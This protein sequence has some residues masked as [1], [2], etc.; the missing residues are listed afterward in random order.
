MWKA[1]LRW[2]FCE[3][4][5]KCEQNGQ[6]P[7]DFGEYNLRVDYDCLADTLIGGLIQEFNSLERYHE[8][9]MNREPPRGIQRPQFNAGC[10]SGDIANSP[11]GSIPWF[12]HWSRVRYNLELDQT[13]PDVHRPDQDGRLWHYRAKPRRRCNPDRNYALESDRVFDWEFPNNEDGPSLDFTTLG[14]LDRILE[15]L[16]AVTDGECDYFMLENVS[17]STAIMLDDNTTPQ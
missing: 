14:A 4:R 17:C 8:Y 7:C 6:W 2:T 3:I 1:M 11:R 13:L 5:D 10:W 12:L 15:R 9:K 16:R